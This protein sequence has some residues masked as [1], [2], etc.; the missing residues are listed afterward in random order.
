FYTAKQQGIIHDIFKG[1]I[2]PDWYKRV[3]QQLKDDTS[4]KPWGAE[5]S[6]AIF[7]TPGSGKF[8]FVMTG[9]HMTIRA[10]GSSENQ[11]AFGGPIFYGHA[12]Q[13]FNE[14]A[15]HPGNVYWPQALMANKVYTM[16]DKGQQA[17]A[18]VKESP[19]ESEVEFRGGKGGFPGIPVNS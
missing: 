10:D 19:H 14:K 1:V 15:D 4:G 11:V 3:L 5:Q 17:R 12:A 8:E 7:G 13:G 6:I 9:R 16:L 18:L 2:N